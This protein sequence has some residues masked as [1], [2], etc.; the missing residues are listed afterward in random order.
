MTRWPLRIVLCLLLGVVTTVGVAV[1]ASIVV[2]P[3]MNEPTWGKLE[4]DGR[5]G[6][7][8]SDAEFFRVRNR[9]RFVRTSSSR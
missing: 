5:R 7:P 4:S 8:L 2:N 6:L 9:R 1:I 3:Y